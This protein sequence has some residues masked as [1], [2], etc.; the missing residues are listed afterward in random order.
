MTLLLVLLVTLGIGLAVWLCL[1]GAR[2]LPPTP[3]RD[4]PPAQEARAVEAKADQDAR[5]TEARAVAEADARLDERRKT[6]AVEDVNAWLKRRR[7]G[8]ALA[9]LVFLL[10]ATVRAE[11]VRHGEETT[12]ATADIVELDVGLAQAEHDRDVEAAGRQ[13][14]EAELVAARARILALEAAPA[15]C[16]L[17]PE[18]TRWRWLAGGFATGALVVLVAV[19]LAR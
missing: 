8:G 5:A 16:P 6:D 7:G 15:P 12:C 11:C 18:D 10:P 14:A 1:R 9:L 19:G 3:V 4:T 17:P 2:R 13:R